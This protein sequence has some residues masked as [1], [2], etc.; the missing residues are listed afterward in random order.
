[1]DEWIS[2]YARSEVKGIA[3]LFQDF[4]DTAEHASSH[5]YSVPN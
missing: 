1:M 3:E 4:S 5:Q 2:R